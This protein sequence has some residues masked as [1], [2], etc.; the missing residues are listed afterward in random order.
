MGE[1]LYPGRWLQGDESALINDMWRLTTA[2]E[3]G[4]QLSLRRSIWSS[5]YGS[6][7]LQAEDGRHDG[8]NRV[9]ANRARTL[10]SAG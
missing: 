3:L 1:T 2:E 5:S 4:E 8:E 7:P 9:V 6:L 10:D